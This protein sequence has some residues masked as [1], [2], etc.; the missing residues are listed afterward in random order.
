MGR[1]K[2]AKPDPEAFSESTLQGVLNCYAADVRALKEISD[3]ILNIIS[4]L[5]IR[6]SQLEDVVEEL[7]RIRSKK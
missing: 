5:E 1:I 3:K 2:L 4:Y 6:F 7:I